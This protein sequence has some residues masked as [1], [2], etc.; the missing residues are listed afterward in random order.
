V[1]RSLPA[2][3]AVAATVKA[4]PLEATREGVPGSGSGTAG[5]APR[6]AAKAGLTEG[7]SEASQCRN[8][9]S[10]F[11]SGLVGGRGLSPLTLQLLTGRLR[12]HRHSRG[13]LAEV[14]VDQ[15][16]GHP[17]VRSGGAVDGAPGG[18]GRQGLLE[19]GS[20]LAGQ[21]VAGRDDQAV[22][23]GAEPP[24]D[25]LVEAGE[26]RHHFQSGVRDEEMYAVGTVAAAGLREVSW[27]GGD[28]DHSSVAAGKADPLE[29]CH[30]GS[31]RDLMDDDNFANNVEIAI[32]QFADGG[33]LSVR[34]GAAKTHIVKT[35]YH[36]RCISRKAGAEVVHLRQ[37]AGDRV[38]RW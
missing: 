4:A 29:V 17:G 11:G 34:I 22:R 3:A 1:S 30:S 37:D 15:C 26:I 28:D 27:A 35:I 7:G 2:V 14:A 12:N 13:G 5:A 21:Q 16:E 32:L 31:Q 24:L 33:N 8:Q 9:L 23:A 25:K 10:G 36:N 6:E 19:A 18:E 20:L 38:R